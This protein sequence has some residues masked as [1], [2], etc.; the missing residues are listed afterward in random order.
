MTHIPIPRELVERAPTLYG[1]TGDIKDI[2]T[3]LT[4][5]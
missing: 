1:I 4:L 5:S 2:N 3:L